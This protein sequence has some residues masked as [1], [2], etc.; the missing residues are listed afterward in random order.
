MPRRYRPTNHH[1]RPWS[2]RRP[3]VGPGRVG[4]GARERGGRPEPRPPRC[5][6]PDGS[7]DLTASYAYGDSRRPATGWPCWPRCSRPRP[8]RSSPRA[9]RPGGRCRRRPGVRTGLHHPAAVGTTGARANGRARSLGAF[10]ARARG[11]A[12][13]RSALAARRGRSATTSTVGALPG[14][15][16]PRSCFARYLLAHLRDTDRPRDA[17][18]ARS[19]RRVAG[20]CSRRSC[21]STPTT[22]CS[23]R[24]VELVTALSVAH[25]NDLLVGRRSGGSAAA[26][27][28]TRPCTTTVTIAPDPVRPWPRLFA[29]NLGSGAR[30]SGPGPRSIPDR[31]TALAADLR[32]ARR[33]APA[34]A[35]PSPGATASSPTSATEPPG[36]SAE[37]G[38]RAHSA[39]AAS[40]WTKCPQSRSRNGPTWRSKTQGG[41]AVE[42]G[43]RSR[44]R[45]ARTG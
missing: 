15:R 29:M 17:G 40:H 9:T 16:R 27:R 19:R 35:A 1:D 21:R 39:W 30:A 37:R 11:R 32:R 20:C 4:R 12:G 31:W 43:R 7:P 42:V 22:P 38:H 14:R 8:P 36:R 33:R 28:R 3:P 25:G 45:T 10:V 13:R 24:Y 26:G 44:G 5:G 18:S 23:G 34:D 2:A 6:V 41:H